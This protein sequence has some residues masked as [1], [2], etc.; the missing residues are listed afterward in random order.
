MYRAV[1]LDLDGTLLTDDKKVSEENK[2]AIKYVQEKGGIACI[3]SGRQKDAVK[4]Y[5]EMAGCD[6]YIICSNGTQIY[7]CEKDEE[8]FSCNLEKD[9]CT[10][11]V[12]YVIKNNFYIRI[13]TSYCRYVNSRDYFVK[14]EI[15]LD[16]NEELFEIINEN[17]ILQITI[18]TNTEEDMKKV[19]KDIEN[20]Q[21]E[22][23]KIENVYPPDVHGAK[24]W[25][26]NIIN[27]NASKGNAIYGLCKYLKINIEDV[28]AMGDDSNDISMIK[29]VGLGIAMGNA[30]EDVK[31]YA[32]EI[33]KTNM[34]NGVADVL[35]KKF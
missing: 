32:K 30:G 13:E 26:A 21:R 31:E 5:K 4:A 15:V 7:D 34:E 19:L 33:T 14:Y 25:S 23:I 17:N 1:F 35:Y 3:C 28:I 18:G 12:N 29:A 20:M 2:K 8:L 22:D 9:I 16:N 11:L 27:K 6:K 10:M 24:A